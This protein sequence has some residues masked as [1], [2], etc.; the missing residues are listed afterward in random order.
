MTEYAPKIGHYSPEVQR[1]ANY[2][3]PWMKARRESDSNFQYLMRPA[4]SHLETVFAEVEQGLENNYVGMADP[5]EADQLKAI[6][7]PESAAL[8]S[9]D[10]L[11]N[12]LFNSSF[13]LVTSQDRLPD[14]WQPEGTGTLA[15]GAGILGTRSLEFQ[16][17]ASQWAAAYQESE[18]PIRAGELWVFYIWYACQVTGTVPATGFGLE[19][20]GTHGDA[21]TETLRASFEA[22]TLGYPKRLVLR[23]SFIQDVVKWKFRIVATNSVGFPVTSLVVDAAWACP[24]D[25]AKEWKPH[26]LEAPPHIALDTIAPVV[27]E[28]PYRAQ[29]AT[30]QEDF[31]D[32]AIPTRIGA[33]SSLPSTGTVDPVPSAGADGFA[34]YASAGR[35]VEVDFWKKEW[36][37]TWQ[38][39]YQASD[40]RIRGLTDEAGDVLGPFTIA[41]QNYRNWFDDSHAWAPE[42]MTYFHDYL[43]VVLQKQDY[44]GQTKRYLAV[45]EPKHARPFPTYLEA[46]VLLELTGIS[47]ATR[48]SR[49]E[50]RWSDQQHLYVGDG[51]SEWVYR[52]HYDYFILDSSAKVLYLREDYGLVVPQLMVKQQQNLSLIP[53]R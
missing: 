4:G 53:R 22:D 36:P 43:W 37:G 49:V 12:R 23:G 42:G 48:L 32:R 50:L 26:I 5:D 13:E 11:E 25:T 10:Y 40:P 27:L 44:L 21:S 33:L 51:Q 52:L 47:L 35:F 17:T 8:V 39:G 15:I 28:H 14:F 18:L 31:W 20:V 1:V 9:P 41:F 38:L 3:P 7:L 6:R 24:G 46:R 2:L 45:V 16:L 29:F 19:V 34:V 30:S